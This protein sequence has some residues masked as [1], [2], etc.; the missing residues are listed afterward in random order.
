MY[1]YRVTEK[2]IV[3]PSEDWVTGQVVGRDM[4]TL[5]TCAPIPVF[6]KRLIFRADRV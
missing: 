2:F 1:T 3:D 4:V 5:P 6:N